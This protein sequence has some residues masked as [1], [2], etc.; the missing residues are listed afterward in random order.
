M[1]NSPRNHSRKGYLPRLIA[2]QGLAGAPLEEP[3]LTLINN[4]RLPAWRLCFIFCHARIATNC[5]KSQTADIIDL[6]ARYLLCFLDLALVLIAPF[7]RV[8]RGAFVKLRELIGGGPQFLLHDMPLYLGRY[9][10]SPMADIE[11]IN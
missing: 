6:E 7:G 2:S 3:Y 8:R 4:N 10:L 11:L 5:S 1:N 9:Y